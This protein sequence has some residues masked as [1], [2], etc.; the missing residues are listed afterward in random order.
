M[1]AKDLYKPVNPVSEKVSNLPSM[2]IPDQ[3]YT[4]KQLL[5]F[6]ARGINPPIQHNAEFDDEFEEELNPLRKKNL[7]L[8]DIDQI[9]ENIDHSMTVID[10]LR[11]S[12]KQK[13]LENEKKRLKD[14]AVKEYQ[15]T[16]KEKPQ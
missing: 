8:T 1:T 15:E 6:H 9:K 3:S 2:T 14:E 5:E 10:K 4:I 12:K 7:D 11:K 16:L 13:E